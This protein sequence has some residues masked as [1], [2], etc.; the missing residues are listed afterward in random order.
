MKI[1][2]LV[3][4]LSLSFASISAQTDSLRLPPYQRYPKS[5]PLKL[6]LTD[7]STY[8]TKESLAKKKPVLIMLFSPD[9]NHC[10]QE[11]E[12]MIKHIESLKNIQIVMATTQPFPMMKEFYIKY[13][14]ARFNN[15][16]V[17]R[18]ENFTLPVYYDIRNYPFFAFYDRKKELITGI[19]GSVGIDKI[20]A[21]FG[22][23]L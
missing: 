4:L 12:E 10:Q 13:G 3:T 8:F 19:E 6:L 9:C 18:E 21:T 15:I 22:K 17:G 7:S 23:E 20:M 11:T 1:L 5:I 16:I 2:F 14:L